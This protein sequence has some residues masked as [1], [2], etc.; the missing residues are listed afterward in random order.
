MINNHQGKRGGDV[1]KRDFVKSYLKSEEKSL[2]CFIHRQLIYD[3]L[4][5]VC[6]DS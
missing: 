2:D 6:S 4:W 3:L 5:K 1:A